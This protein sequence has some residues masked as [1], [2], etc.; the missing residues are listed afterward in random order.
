MQSMMLAFLPYLLSGKPESVI[1]EDFFQNFET[2]K[3]TYCNMMSAKRYCVLLLGIF[4]PRNCS[5]LLMIL[6]FE[7]I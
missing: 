2:N 1:R 5:A 7:A 6:V 3:V 4:G